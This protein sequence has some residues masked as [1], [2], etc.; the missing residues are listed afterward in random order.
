MSKTHCF[1]P[2]TQIRPGVKTNH[3]VAAGNYIA[4]KRPDVIVIGGDWW[5]MNSLSSY[6]K[7]G[8]KGW[9][10]KDL[11]EDFHCGVVAMESFMAAV[12]NRT[13]QVG[14]SY[15]PEVYFLMGN[16]EDR[17]RRAREHPDSRRFSEYLTDANFQLSAWDIRVI[18]F[19]GI[20]KID[21]ILY[22]HYFENPDSLLG[23]CIG[24]AIENKLRK[25][26]HSFTMGHQQTYQS[27][28]IYTATGER[29]R[30]LVCGSFYQHE[31]EYRSVQKN[32]QHWRG[33]VFKHEV[34]NG[35]YDLM[36]VSLKYLLKEYS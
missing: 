26:G 4:A 35:D 8:Q 28:S 18:P 23:N 1:I 32:K 25:L 11:F 9:E 12:H 15:N 17:V 21:G 33:I 19:L 14:C 36:E 7:A 22:S 24:G 16:H 5:D 27:G 30:G 6:D 31:E 10:D 13:L 20:K 2:D 34:K 3:I 29:R